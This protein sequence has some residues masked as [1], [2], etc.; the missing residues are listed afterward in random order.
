MTRSPP[1]QE[2]VKPWRGR[3][4]EGFLRRGI[5]MGEGTPVWKLMWGSF[6]LNLISHVIIACEV[7]PA[8]LSLTTKPAPLL[9][10]AHRRCD[11]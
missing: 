8:I 5:I 11:A 6:Q 2:G 9:G 1:K 10:R 3:S 7:R 4:A